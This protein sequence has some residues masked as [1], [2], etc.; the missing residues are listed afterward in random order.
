[1]LLLDEAFASV[2]LKLRIELMDL[3]S[4]L[5]REEKRTTIFVT[6]D[7]QDALYLADRILVFSSRPAR[8]LDV[9]SIDTPREDRSYGSKAF[10][11]LEEL[12]YRKILS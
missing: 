3:F 8:L 12:L 10:S 7:V 4:L 6:H 9:L 1:V 5:W 2:D 11:E